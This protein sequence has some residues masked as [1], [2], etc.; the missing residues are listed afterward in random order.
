[1]LTE[2]EANAILADLYPRPR[3]WRRSSKGNLWRNYVG[4][5]LTVF[6]R[7][8]GLYGYCLRPR[9]GAARFS[10]EGW[11]TEREAVD[12]VLGEVNRGRLACTT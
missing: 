8:D 1:M 9:K 6:P 3:T 7:W 5:R 10:T 12:A 4:A 2:T 11:P